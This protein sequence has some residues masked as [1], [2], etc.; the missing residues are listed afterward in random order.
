VQDNHGIQSAQ[1]IRWMLIAATDRS[2]LCGIV[3]TVGLRLPW[4]LS[5]D[6]SGFERVTASCPVVM[7]RR[8]Y[9]SLGGP[10]PG[11][12]NVV[13]T[14]RRGFSPGG[15]VVAHDAAAVRQALHRD[16]S[17]PPPE[18]FLVGGAVVFGQFLPDARRLHLTEAGRTFDGNCI[19]ARF[20]Q[21]GSR[22]IGWRQAER[23][24]RLSDQG[25]EY[26]FVVYERRRAEER[27][28]S[29]SPAY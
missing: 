24:R 25:C 5:D 21:G 8:T 27:Q 14:R 11:R 13:L 19:F 20:A 28:D 17:A 29:W 22:R 12:L 18:A 4:Y 26:D 6:M 16:G 2:R 10:L 7:G 3:E 23:E 1:H 9:E 15:V